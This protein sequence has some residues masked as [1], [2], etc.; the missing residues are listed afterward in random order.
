MLILAQAIALTIKL[1]SIFVY[2]AFE[3]LNIFRFFIVISSDGRKNPTAINAKFGV[4]SSSMHMLVVL[5]SVFFFC[6]SFL[7]YLWL[8]RRTLFLSLP[9]T[10]QIAVSPCSEIPLP[11]FYLLNF[12]GAYN[13]D[14]AKQFP[15][16]LCPL[17]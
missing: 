16:W 6:R 7:F 14:Q 8:F 15:L 2:M 10:L 12:V 4:F 9:N 11:F 3:H 17:T 13:C 5:C 1:Y